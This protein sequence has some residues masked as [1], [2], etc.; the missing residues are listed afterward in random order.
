LIAKIQLI[1]GRQEQVP[2]PGLVEAP[3]DRRANQ[4]AVARDENAGGWRHEDLGSIACV[5]H[6]S[7]Y[8]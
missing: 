1:A 8:A 6:G 2:V 3:Y 5:V 4:A 7:Y